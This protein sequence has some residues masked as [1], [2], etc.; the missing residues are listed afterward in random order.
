MEDTG[1]GKNKYWCE[2]FAFAAKS[3]FAAK[4]STKKFSI[5]KLIFKSLRLCGE[6]AGFF[7]GEIFNHFSI[8][9]KWFCV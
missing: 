3:W 6:M 5:R 8:Q 2:K 1:K 9:A 7:R 4:T